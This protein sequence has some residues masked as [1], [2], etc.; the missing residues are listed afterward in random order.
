[1]IA[2]AP[3]WFAALVTGRMPVW[4]FTFTSGYVAYQARVQAYLYLLTDQYPP[5]SWTAPHYPVQLDMPERGRLGR[6]AVLLR[7]VLAIPTVVMIGALT[8]GWN[9]VGF[10]VRLVM[11]LPAGCRDRHSRPRRRCCG[12]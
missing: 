4:A 9:V 3:G 12:F 10:S 7:F 1:M 2:L 11:L 6:L 5:F 8:W